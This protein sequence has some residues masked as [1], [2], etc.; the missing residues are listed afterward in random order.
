MSYEFSKACRVLATRCCVCHRD[1]VD[2]DSVDLGIGPICRKRY[3]KPEPGA[4]ESAAAFAALTQSQVPTEILEA[5]AVRPTAREQ[6]NMLV[7]WASANIDDSDKVLSIAP[8]LRL[9]GYNALADKLVADRTPIQIKLVGEACCRHS[10]GS[11]GTG[12]KVS[13]SSRSHD[14]RR[15]ERGGRTMRVNSSDVADFEGCR[16]SAVEVRPGVHEYPYMD[17]ARFRETCGPDEDPDRWLRKF[18]FQ[19]GKHGADTDMRGDVVVLIWTDAPDPH[20]TKTLAVL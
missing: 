2:A 17:V 20:L 18:R 8:A 9:L 6:A 3:M 1:L 10:Q 7:Y 12:P 13:S 16:R 19:A 4:S 11:A 15:D 14:G 5:V